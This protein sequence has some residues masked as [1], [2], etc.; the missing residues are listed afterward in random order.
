MPLF[1]PGESVDDA[2]LAMQPAGY[3]PIV[4]TSGTSI[5]DNS[6]NSRTGTSSGTVTLNNLTAPDGRPAALFGG[7]HIGISDNSAFSLDNLANG[8]SVLALVK[9]SSAPSGR[10]F[11]VSKG[12]NGSTDYE[13]EFV[14]AASGNFTGTIQ[15]QGGGTISGRTSTGNAVGTAWTLLAFSVQSTAASAPINL[16]KDSSSPVAGSNTTSG[17]GYTN[18]AS[19]VRIGAR[20][21]NATTVMAGYIR[22]VCIVPEWVGRGAVQ[23][24]VLACQREG[25]F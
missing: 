11:L 22:N 1:L 9:F 17:S 14:G 5:A 8:F 24:V 19:P 21:D 20:A 12:G 7:G 6:G 2:M 15:T 23:R 4:E 10:M 13:W 3:W 16:F 25:W 18:G